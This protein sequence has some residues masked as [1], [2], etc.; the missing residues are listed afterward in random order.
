MQIT[1][2]NPNNAPY[3]KAPS[4]N[5]EPFSMLE[6]SANNANNSAFKDSNATPNIDTKAQNNANTPTQETTNQEI[7]NIED[8][9]TESSKKPQLN[10]PLMPNTRT[11]YGLKI[12]EQMSE[13]EYQAFLWATDGMSD[14][15]KI[16]AAQSLYR[17]TPFYQGKEQKDIAD[18]NNGASIEARRA[19][20][21]EQGM[22]EDFVNRY[23]N[24][25]D[26][27][28]QGMF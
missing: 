3:T 24:A 7:A 14:T 5:S 10:E 28:L 2:L 6:S 13:N 18:T 12:I 26:R 15:Q 16:F 9:K 22:I 8:T 11:T 1:A 21:I 4:A 23:K 25:Y 27:V 19:L 17:F 20:G